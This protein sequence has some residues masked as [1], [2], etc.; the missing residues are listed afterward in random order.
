MNHQRPGFANEPPGAMLDVESRP[1]WRDRG[2]PVV[3]RTAM[4]RSTRGA[5]VL[6]C[7]FATGCAWMHREPAPEPVPTVPPTAS[8]PVEVP[9]AA[10][11]Q[12]EVTVPSEVVAPDKAATAAQSSVIEPARPSAPVA[13]PRTVV[14]KAPPAAVAPVAKAAAPGPPPPLPDATQRAEGCART[15]N[16]RFRHAASRRAARFQVARDATPADQGYWRD[17]QAVTEERGR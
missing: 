1:A 16:C 12:Q 10:A 4:F 11:P 3:N 9:A 17:D 15:G 14:P 8:V 13:A 6:S 7:V 2:R 5:I